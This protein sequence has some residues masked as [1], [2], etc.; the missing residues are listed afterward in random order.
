MKTLTNVSYGST[1]PL[2]S[3]VIH[4]KCEILLFYTSCFLNL[5]FQDSQ[6]LLALAMPNHFIQKHPT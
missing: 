3:E 6:V 5:C 1:Y 2:Y 4:I